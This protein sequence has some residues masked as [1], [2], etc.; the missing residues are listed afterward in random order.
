MILRATQF[1]E[2]IDWKVERDRVDLAQLAI[3]LLGPAP[4]RKGERGRRWWWPCP[5]HND[6]NPSFY[7][8]PDKPWWKCLGCGERGDAANLLMR[9]E[10]IG[11]ADAIRR[12]TDGHLGATSYRPSPRPVASTPPAGPKGLPVA[13]ALALVVA[14]EERLWGDEGIEAR[15][16]LTRERRLTEATIRAARLGWTSGV[17]LPTQD[18]RRFTARGVVVPWP[19]GDRLALVKIRQPVDRRPKYAEAFRNRPEIF[20]GGPL[21]R[22]GLPLVIV[23]GEFDALLLG[24]ELQELASVVTLGSASA[25]PDGSTLARLFGLF[26]WFIATDADEAGDRAAG[27]WHGSSH[28]VRPPYPYNDWTEAGQ[29][30]VN[31]RRWWSDRLMETTNPPLFDWPELAAWRW[32]PAVGEVD[33]GIIIDHPN[34]ERLRIALASLETGPGDAQEPR[35]QEAQ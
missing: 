15:A 27:E 34:R 6:P 11:F 5:F 24:Q 35:T 26:P 12:L 30:G 19:D 10:K 21:D 17:E 23:E 4:G 13:E 9:L 20:L 22:L 16:Y 25:R 14:A 3:D 33:P 32:R 28:R 8:E 2:R 7:V 31:L 18:G 29:A 1:E